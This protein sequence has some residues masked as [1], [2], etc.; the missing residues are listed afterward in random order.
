MTRLPATIHSDVNYVT[1][2]CVAHGVINE[3]KMLQETRYR[4]RVAI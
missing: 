4:V 1:R 2:L 3:Q